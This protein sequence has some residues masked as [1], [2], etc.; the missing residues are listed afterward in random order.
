[1]KL[2]GK[3]ALI[4]GASSGI[5]WAIA[6][7]LAQQ[8]ARLILTARR[9]ERLESLAVSLKNKYQ[10]V[11]HL[12]A[13]DVQDQAAVSKAI[14]SLPEAWK[15]IDILV[16]NAGLAL[17]SKPFHDC[18]LEQWNTMIDTNVKG[19]L[20]V[21]HAVVQRMIERNAGHIVN[22]GSIAGRESYP[23]GNVYCASKQAVKAISQSLRLDLSGYL[24]RVTEIAPG[25]VNTE[26]ST[27]RWNDKE[28]A[29]TFYKD[30]Q[31]LDANDVAETVLFCITRPPHV[32]ISEMVVFPTDQACATMINRKP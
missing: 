32:N 21:T 10:S 26:F 8:G 14:G 19:L 11:V 5:G 17:A 9:V 30:F 7:Q 25:A 29:D 13:L 2:K 12:I 3:T 4:T 24:I 18:S 28:R 23:G 31:P 1:M 6:E 16:N 22:I 20:F 15:A 27:V